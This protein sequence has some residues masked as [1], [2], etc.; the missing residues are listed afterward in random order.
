MMQ[1]KHPEKEEQTKPKTSKWREIIKI[2]AKINEIKTKTTTQRINGSLKR[3]TRLAS[4]SQHN[5]GRK[6]TKLIKSAMKKGT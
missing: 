4:L 3:L 6:K 2:R 5:G 1:I